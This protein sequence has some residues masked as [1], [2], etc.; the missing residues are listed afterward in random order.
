[1]KRTNP[2]FMVLFI[3]TVFLLSAASVWA[4]D[5]PAFDQKP[6]VILDLWANGNKG[7]Y[8]DNVKVRNGI[9]RENIIFNV[10]GYDEKK[11][12]WTLIGP[13]PL[14]YHADSENIDKVK[15]VS[16]K[17]FRWFAVH[18]PNNIQF[19]A[20]ALTNRNDVIITVINKAPGA[21]AAAPQ[22]NNAPAFDLQ[23]S[24]VLDLWEKV[25]G[26]YKDK[27]NIKNA[28]GTKNVAI[29]VWGYDQKSNQ[30][31]LIGP[32]RLSP[33]PAPPPV[34]FFNGFFWVSYNPA[35]DESVDTTWEGKINSFRWI[36][37]QSLDG[38]SFDA[39]VAA[40]SNDLNLTVIKK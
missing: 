7:K 32:K 1:M 36:A 27:I 11:K 9:A 38:F 24:K 28:M 3:V 40:S 26:K 14:K 31:I 19:D 10:Y 20:L 39:D 13:A 25:K 5:A 21:L 17:N 15:G 33:D 23:S 34:T 35:T 22:G 8:K 6:S 30:W 37:V 16:I 12:E 4:Q 29:N 18:S 2:V